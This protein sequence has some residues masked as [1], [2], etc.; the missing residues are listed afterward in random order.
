[1]MLPSELI[2]LAL[3]D[4][5][6]CESSSRYEVSMDLWHYPHGDKCYVCL[7]GAVMA[8]TLNCPPDRMMFPHQLSP[9]WVDRLLSLEH[10]RAGYVNAGL[11]VLRLKNIM[12]NRGVRD[13]ECNRD[14][15]FED[16]ELMASDLEKEGL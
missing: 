11:Y 7:A 15:F 3:E 12:I 16:M 9:E 13:Y 8:Q 6:K 10:F 14:G 4:L 2:R 5:R 1:M